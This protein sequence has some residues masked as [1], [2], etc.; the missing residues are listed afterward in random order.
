MLQSSIQK[1]FFLDRDGVI[2]YD[3]GYLTNFDQVIYLPGIGEFLAALKKLQFKIFVVTNQSAVARGMIS[4]EDAIMLNRRILKGV[5]SLYPGANIDDSEICPFHPKGIIAD[6]QKDS[7][8]RKPAPGMI[9]ALASRYGIDLPSSYMV[10]DKESDIIAGKKAGC[11]TFLFKGAK[12][13]VDP[14]EN[15]LRPDWVVDSF[16]EILE[17]FKKNN[18]APTNQR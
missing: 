11:R 8:M 4:F 17:C 15:P 1:A 12:L 7:P 9:L 14:N 3:S 16:A 2:N 6:F 18:N 13:P 10:G 5:N